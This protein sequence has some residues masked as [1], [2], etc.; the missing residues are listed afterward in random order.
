MVEQLQIDKLSLFSVT[1]SDLAERM[2]QTAL[3]LVGPNAV[4]TDAS[5]CIGGNTISFARSFSHVHAVEISPTRAR[6]LQHNV[7]AAGVEGRVTVHCGD[8]AQV[9]LTVKGR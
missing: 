1:R 7:T 4:V 2:T 9:P 8:G 3:R 6:L 5:A